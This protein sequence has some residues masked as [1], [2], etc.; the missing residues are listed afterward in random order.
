[1]VLCIINTIGIIG[2]YNCLRDAW[3]AR[4][5]FMGG[6]HKFSVMCVYMYEILKYKNKHMYVRKSIYC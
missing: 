3:A 6:N 1:M 5:Y 4:H 2:R